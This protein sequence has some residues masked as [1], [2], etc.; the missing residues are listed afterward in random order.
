MD[1]LPAHPSDGELLGLLARGDRTALG[2][3]V[4]RHQSA[5]LRHARA[6]LGDA[7][8]HCE[9][10]IQETFLK[11]LERPPE[12]PADVRGDA[13]RERAQLSSWLHKVARNHCMDILRAEGRRRQ[14]EEASAAPETAPPGC[15]DGAEL[16][17]QRDTR[18]RVEAELARLPAEQRE[19]LVLRLLGERSYKEIA[20]ITGKKI[21]T[22]G[23]LVSEGLRALSTGL[24]PLVAVEASRSG[25]FGRGGGR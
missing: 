6:L 3:L 13:G 5:L 8:G 19:V 2:E 25:Q 4:R 23:W 21:G 15:A 20:E 7:G 16:V 11:L 12:L 18:A 22:V 1:D 24:A 10:A 17:E 9:D 14:R